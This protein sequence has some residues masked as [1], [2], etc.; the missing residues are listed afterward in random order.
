MNASHRSSSLRN[1]IVALSLAMTATASADDSVMIWLATS[2]SNAPCDPQDSCSQSSGLGCVAGRCSPV[3]MEG[4]ACSPYSMLDRCDGALGCSPTTGLCM[5]AGGQ[6]QPCRETP[7]PACESNLACVMGTCV[8]AGGEGQPCGANATCADGLF[9][10]DGACVIYPRGLVSM[11][12][13]AEASSCVGGVPDA[14]ARVSRSSPSSTFSFFAKE[15]QVLL[16]GNQVVHPF[17]TEIELGGVNTQH[18]QSILRLPQTTDQFVISR[19]VDGEGVAGLMVVD[20]SEARQFFPT[21]DVDHPGGMSIFGHTIAVAAEHAKKVIST[22]C[23]ALDMCITEFDEN[24]GWIDF[25]KYEPNKPGSLLRWTHRLD[26]GF[27]AGGH[28]ASSVAYTKTPD[29]GELAF[30]LGARSET[31]WLVQRSPASSSWR[32]VQSF[33]SYFTFLPHTVPSIDSNGFSRLP[34]GWKSYQNIHFVTDC[35]GYLYLVGSAGNGAYANTN[36]E[37]FVDLFRLKAQSRGVFYLDKIQGWQPTFDRDRCD[38]TYAGNPIVAN[39][40]LEYICSDG[41]S[42]ISNSKNVGVAEYR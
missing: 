4:Q 17:Q 38:L 8:P 14:L 16:P 6:Q 19:D 25:W 29:G 7:A 3:R 26:T 11:A 23:N 21:F 42:D 28:R 13:T 37:N 20:R 35:N 18:V 2:G 15:G 12:D 10:A 41:T 1:L 34:W 40:T 32:H 31:A 24:A 36:R 22:S 39:G 5:P 30:I 27:L 33:K 9:C